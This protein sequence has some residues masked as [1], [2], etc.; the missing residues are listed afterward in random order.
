V[1]HSDS[2][3]ATEEEDNGAGFDLEEEARSATE[4]SEDAK[5]SLLEHSPSLRAR[6]SLGTS[7]SSRALNGDNPFMAV[8]Y[9]LVN[10]SVSIPCLYGYAGIIYRDPQF[11]ESLPD[12][13][14]LVI[15]SSAVHQLV[16]SL[17]SSLPFAVAQVQ[18]AGLIFLSSMATTIA[19]NTQSREEAVATTVVCLSLATAALGLCVWLVGRFRLAN[20]V[21]L[22][23][24]PVVA[25]Y[26]AFIGFFCFAAGL[27]LSCSKDISTWR[28]F[29]QLNV[30]TDLP[31]VA[32][33]VLG[34]ACMCLVS[35]YSTRW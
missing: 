22:I 6:A 4:F 23:P 15:L 35:R 24:M 10:V 8:V 34:G 32:P 5:A 13:A 18:D 17:K 1:G 11:Q 31:F 2:A 12:L 3:A 19:R 25:G 21:T 7:P 30:D 33:A 20:I 14:K 29:A 27:G 28:D 26:L 9:G 16:F